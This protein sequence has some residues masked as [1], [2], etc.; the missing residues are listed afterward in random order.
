VVPF[1][2]D[3]LEVSG[4]TSSQP[5]PVVQVLQLLPLQSCQ[6]GEFLLSSFQHHQSLMKPQTRQALA[7]GSSF[8]LEAQATS[9]R[10]VRETLGTSGRGQGL[11]RHQAA[12]KVRAMA[13]MAT[14]HWRHPRP[15]NNHHQPT[16][17]YMYKCIITLLHDHQPRLAHVFHARSWLY[18]NIL[19]ASVHHFVIHR[20]AIIL[21]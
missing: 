15:H 4:L 16:Y 17:M 12:G 18:C 11:A 9:T 20:C 19:F 8:W 5:P 13:G 6:V 7:A 2:V 10:G 1:A 21:N 14:E 3:C